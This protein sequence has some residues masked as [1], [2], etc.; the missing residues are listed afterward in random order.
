MVKSNHEIALMQLAN[1]ATL[2]AY[3]ATYR[4]LKEGMTQSD[5]S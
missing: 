2:A 5:V 3:E 1:K 4:A